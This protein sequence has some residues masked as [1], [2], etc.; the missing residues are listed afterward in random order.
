MGAPVEVLTN[1]SISADG[2]TGHI[3]AGLLNTPSLTW[4]W[5]FTISGTGDNQVE[6]TPKI[7]LNYDDP[8]AS[9][10]YSEIKDTREFDW[11]L[12]VDSD[13]VDDATT[14]R[15]AI[16]NP[17]SF[18]FL[19]FDYDYEGGGSRTFTLSIKLIG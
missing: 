7:P 13:Q 16:T 2:D 18:S 8:S 14:L 15:Y 4:V 11:P 19:Q 12:W 5:T 6:F 17:N 9:Q 10:V 1:E 3:T